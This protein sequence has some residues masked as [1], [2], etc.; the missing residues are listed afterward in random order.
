MHTSL[1]VP[2]EDVK[3]TEHDFFKYVRLA[4]GE[5]RFCRVYNAHV[6]IVKKDE[7]VISAGQIGVRKDAF[8]FFAYGSQTLGIKFL[9]SDE[10][11]LT[12]ILDKKCIWF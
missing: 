10:D 3:A 2:I 5:F 11:E 7:K 4:S 8:K 12:R 9:N 6:E 1:T